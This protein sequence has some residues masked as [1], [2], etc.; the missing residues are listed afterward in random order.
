MAEKAISFY[1]PTVNNLAKQ[2]MKD[3]HTMLFLLQ[4]ETTLVSSMISKLQVDS[5]LAKLIADV[6][7]QTGTLISSNDAGQS[8]DMNGLRSF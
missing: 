1:Q 4:Y 8:I 2:T 7:H 6:R 3:G 5:A